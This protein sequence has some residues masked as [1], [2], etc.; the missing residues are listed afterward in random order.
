MPGS[1]QKVTRVDQSQVTPTLRV[2]HGTGLSDYV[3]RDLDF[4]DVER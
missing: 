4:S 2:K 1:A 3:A